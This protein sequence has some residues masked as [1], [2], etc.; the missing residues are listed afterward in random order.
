MNMVRGPVHVNTTRHPS[1]FSFRTTCAAC[2][3]FQCSSTGP[4][5]ALAP[6]PPIAKTWPEG[7]VSKSH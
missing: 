4:E 5:G 2:D 1:P 7:L 6:S 3:V